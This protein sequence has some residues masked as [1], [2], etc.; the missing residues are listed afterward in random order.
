VQAGKAGTAASSAKRKMG[1]RLPIL[2]PWCAQSSRGS[3]PKPRPTTLPKPFG[4]SRALISSESSD[5]GEL[6][7]CRSETVGSTRFASG[8][9][10][11]GRRENLAEPWRQKRQNGD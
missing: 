4:I 6:A 1:R 8:M 10:T 11:R 5:L 2:G 7:N 9:I 3:A